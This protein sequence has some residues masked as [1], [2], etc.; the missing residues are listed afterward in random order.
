M[1]M[2]GTAAVTFDSALRASRHSWLVMLDLYGTLLTVVGVVCALVYVHGFDPSRVLAD[3]WGNTATVGYAAVCLAIAAFCFQSAAAI[4]GRFDFQSELVWVELQG[5]W[6]SSRIGTGNQLNSRL[7]TENDVVRVEAMTLRVW[8]ARVES[9]VFG[10]DGQR[11]VTAMYAT[12]QEASRMADDLEAFAARQSVFVA[13]RAAEDRHRIDALQATEALL[14][15]RAPARA[16][17]LAGTQDAPR[18]AGA[19]AGAGAPAARFCT[20]CGTKA[21]PQA[22]FCSACGTALPP[23]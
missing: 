13:P 5:T 17:A 11:Q 12:S 10:K 1:P 16:D 9:V 14:G 8:R 20:A 19:G 18:I 3:G 15:G 4:W 7:Q 23:A 22:K 2:P 21:S 6:Q